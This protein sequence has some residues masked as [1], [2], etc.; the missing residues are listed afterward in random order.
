MTHTMGPQLSEKATTYNQQ[1]GDVDDHRS[2]AGEPVHHDVDALAPI[3]T[4][5]RPARSPRRLPTHPIYE[6]EGNKC[7]NETDYAEADAVQDRRGVTK[8]RLAQERRA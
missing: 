3:A 4:P 1:A 5:F 2:T 7:R 8:A 6:D